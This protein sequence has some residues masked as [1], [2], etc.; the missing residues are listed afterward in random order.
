MSLSVLLLASVVD[1]DALLETTL[2]ALIAGL[3]VAVSFS[4]VIV[5]STR[6]ADLR[7]AGRDVAALAAGVLAAA[8]I[9]LFLTVIGV[10]MLVLVGG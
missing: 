1:A 8:G 7:R 9:I 6:S 4:L 10:G 3:A 2:S 5:G